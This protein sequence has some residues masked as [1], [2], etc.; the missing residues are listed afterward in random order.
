MTVTDNQ[1][2]RQERDLSN[3]FVGE[4]D[5]QRKRRTA[6]VIGGAAVAVLVVVALILAFALGRGSGGD[7]SA[8][9]GN[10]PVSGTSDRPAELS[11]AGWE[12]T[13]AK[14]AGDD[15]WFY[16]A[17]GFDTNYVVICLHDE[18]DPSA[19]EGRAAYFHD[20]DTMD[21]NDW[22]RNGYT[23]CPDDVE[24]GEHHQML[25]ADGSV[26]FSATSRIDKMYG[27]PDEFVRYKDYWFNDSLDLSDLYMCPES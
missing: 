5:R 11:D 14:C 15:P 6:L 13:S 23:V 4:A 9:G 7:D 21:S 24:A 8:E 12:G 10:G 1:W 16:A 20:Q 18:G 22:E 19:P 27:E 17:Q 2:G 3:P 25:G 26:E